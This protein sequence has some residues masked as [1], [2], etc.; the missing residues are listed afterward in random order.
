MAVIPMKA[1]KRSSFG[2]LHDG[3]AAAEDNLTLTPQ[4]SGGYNLDPL[5]LTPRRK[6]MQVQSPAQHAAVKKAAAA[7]R[8]KRKIAAGLPIVGSGPKFGV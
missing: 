4:G 5:S 3:F 7:S 6:S 2:D 8:T 1:K